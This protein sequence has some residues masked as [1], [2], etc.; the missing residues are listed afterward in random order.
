MSDL[1]N[2]LAFW[3]DEIGPKYWYDSTPE[4]DATIRERFMPDWKTALA[5]GLQDWLETAEGSLGYIILTDQFPRNMFREDARA[6][7]TDA[8]ACKSAAHAINKNFDLTIDGPLRQ[9]FYLPFEH[10][11]SSD[12]Q[13]RSVLYLKERMPGAKEAFLHARAHQE[14]IRRFGRFPYRNKILN[15]ENTET[16]QIFLSENGYQSILK[17]LQ[18]EEVKG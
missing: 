11:E 17:S 14:I 15:R 8:L 12:D 9:F 2:I 18:N 4:L 3:S 6:F 1:R 5:G 7:A 10:S 16:E 13:A